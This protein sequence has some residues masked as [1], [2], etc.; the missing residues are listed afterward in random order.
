VY[1]EPLGDDAATGSGLSVTGML[2]DDAQLH[3][4]APAATVPGPAQVP[5]LCIALKYVFGDG[6]ASHT[7]TSRVTLYADGTHQVDSA[8]LRQA[9]AP[10]PE[11]AEVATA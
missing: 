5:A 11:R 8:W 9:A 3:A 6:S 7:A 4:R 2:E 10:A 1:V